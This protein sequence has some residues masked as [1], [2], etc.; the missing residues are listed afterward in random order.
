MKCEGEDGLWQDT[1]GF[2]CSLCW[3][4]SCP[5]SAT[6]EWLAKP[7]SLAAAVSQVGDGGQEGEVWGLNNSPRI[8]FLLPC[9]SLVSCRQM[10]RERRRRR[11]PRATRSQLCCRHLWSPHHRYSPSLLP[12][13]PS[14]APRTSGSTGFPGVVTGKLQVI[15]STRISKADLYREYT[16]RDFLTSL[17]L[18]L[19]WQSL[20]CL[21]SCWLWLLSGSPGLYP[22]NAFS[23]VLVSGQTHSVPGE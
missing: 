9:F 15:F 22:D 13:Q 10:R 20:F 8:V 23:L 14:R 2:L 1:A 6:E 17:S 3:E 4:L 7:H 16:H 12:S 5:G 21:M 11:S 18:S 19:W